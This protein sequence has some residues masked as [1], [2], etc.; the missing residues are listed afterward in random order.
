MKGSG[1]N[2]THAYVKPIALLTLNTNASRTIGM[3]LQANISSWKPGADGTAYDRLNL[4]K[5]TI[6]S[7]IHSRG[8]AY[9]AIWDSQLRE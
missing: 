2:A 6:R 8:K 7:A 3:N 4:R 9:K 5:E 1:G